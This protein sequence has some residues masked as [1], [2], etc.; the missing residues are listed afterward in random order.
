MKP[1]ANIELQIHTENL[2]EKPFMPCNGEAINMDNKLSN[3]KGIP[4]RPSASIQGFKRA[5]GR[6]LHVGTACFFR[7]L[8]V[9][10]CKSCHQDFHFYQ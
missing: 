5:F 10:G 9:A 7:S 1:R 8:R 4:R 3:V 6:P 2:S